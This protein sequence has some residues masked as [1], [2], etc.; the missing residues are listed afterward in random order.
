MANPVVS[1][2]ANLVIT[3]IFRNQ[4]ISA[5]DLLQFYKVAIEGASAWYA[6]GSNLGSRVSSVKAFRHHLGWW[7]LMTGIFFKVM[8]SRP[9]HVVAT[10]QEGV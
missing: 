1:D 3:A 4:T 8:T 5:G 7:A 6:V 2:A 10:G 9:T